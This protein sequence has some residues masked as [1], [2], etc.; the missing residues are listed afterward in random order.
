MCCVVLCCVVLC[1]VVLCC[2]ALRCVAWRGVAWRGVASRRVALRCVGGVWLVLRM[3]PAEE[4]MLQLRLIVHPRVAG[5]V[6]D[7]SV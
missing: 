4:S 6:S 2:D 7:Q 3:G 5:C 1:C